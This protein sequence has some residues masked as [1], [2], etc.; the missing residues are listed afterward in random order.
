[1][2]SRPTDPHTETPQ[3]D[4]STRGDTSPLP[5]ATQPTKGGFFNLIA[6]TVLDAVKFQ[7][8]SAWKAGREAGAEDGFKLGQ[9]RGLELG[10]A[11]GRKVGHLEGKSEGFD[12]TV[13]TFTKE[14]KL[15]FAK[16]V[17][18]V[19]DLWGYDVSE[20]KSLEIVRTFHSRI[21]SFAKSIDGL[22]DV[23][24]F[25]FLD[26]KPDEDERDGSMLQVKLG[27]TQLDLMNA[28][29]CRLR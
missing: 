21:L 28:V 14:S 24:A 23:K 6:N 18:E 17:R 11:E 2:D 25:E 19:F 8:F 16:K 29:Y 15:D 5:N 1:M 13:V 7:Q 3:I 20:K 12:E 22:S 4:T 10:R 9:T 27:E 26:N